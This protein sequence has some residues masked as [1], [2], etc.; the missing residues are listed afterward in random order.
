MPKIIFIFLFVEKMKYYK[1]VIDNQEQKS[2]FGL[3]KKS[4]HFQVSF[5]T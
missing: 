5:F 1:E 3:V 2:K 4:K